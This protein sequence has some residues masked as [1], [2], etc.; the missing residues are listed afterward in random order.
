MK[1]ILIFTLL[2]SMNAMAG[3][4]VAKDAFKTSDTS[5]SAKNRCEQVTAKECIDRTGKDTR[6]WKLGLVDDLE[7]Q[8]FSK[9]D[10]ISCSDLSD[11]Q[12]KQATL[13]CSVHGEGSFSVINED[14]DETYCAKPDGFFQKDGLVA[15]AAGTT[16]ADSADV[17]KA[18]EQSTRETKH[19]QRITDAATC[20]SAVNGGGVLNTVQL[21]QCVNVLVKQVFELTILVSDL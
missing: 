10:L 20:V 16:A 19:G 6:K 15:D 3:N 4:W 5:W 8:K 11:C 17:T 7:R 9:E 1:L 12:T 18:A 13:D 21:T 14:F 2:F